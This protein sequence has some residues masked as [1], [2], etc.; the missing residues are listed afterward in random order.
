MNHE[1]EALLRRAAGA[2]AMPKP[3]VLARTQTIHPIP[4]IEGPTLSGASPDLKGA[5]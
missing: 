3:T 5:L 1:F 2:S 4:D